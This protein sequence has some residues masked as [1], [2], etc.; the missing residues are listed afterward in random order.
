MTSLY[1]LPRV[2]IFIIL[3]YC[4]HQRLFIIFFKKTARYRGQQKMRLLY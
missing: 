4:R 2:L 1:H 3:D